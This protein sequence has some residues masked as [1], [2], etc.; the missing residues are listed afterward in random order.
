[1]KTLK[2][3]GF[4]LI[5]LLVVVAIIGILATVVLA[6]LGSARARAKDA[7]VKTLMSQMRTQAEIQYLEN[8]NY[9]NL[10]TLSTQSADLYTSAITNSPSQG[11]NLYCLSS[12]TSA[13]FSRGADVPVSASK[14]ATPGAWA[15]VTRLSDDNFLCVDSTGAIV[16]STSRTIDNDPVDVVC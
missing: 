15:A 14:T 4:T 12:S 16:E 7:K 2:S 10:C 3:K 1:M 5:E 9:D 13:L 11:T 8:D 6:S